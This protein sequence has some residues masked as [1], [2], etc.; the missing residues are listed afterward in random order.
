M[1]VEEQKIA[2]PI[3]TARLPFMSQ[4]ECQE[5]DIF[6]KSKSMN[7]K[8]L[9]PIKGLQKKMELFKLDMPLFHPIMTRNLFMNIIILAKEK[10]QIFSKFKK[11]QE[12]M[13]L[14]INF[15]KAK[16]SQPLKLLL[17]LYHAQQLQL[18][19]Q[20]PTYI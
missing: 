6:Q 8:A 16:D 17:L 10:L 9:L 11:I 19:E 4:K 5:T 13:E 1:T 15:P 2:R 3:Q 20:R 18:S 7:Q 12:I 14:M